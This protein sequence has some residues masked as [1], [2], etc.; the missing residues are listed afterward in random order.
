MLFTTMNEHYTN[1][2]LNPRHY[3]TY[4]YVE[5][6]NK[7]SINRTITAGIDEVI[8]IFGTVRFSL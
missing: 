1:Q 5:N 8:I 6:I 2:E 4:K 7:L 3:F